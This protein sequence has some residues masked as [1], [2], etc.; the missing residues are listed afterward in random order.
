MPPAPRGPATWYVP[1]RVPGERG[2]ASEC[3]PPRAGSQP[4]PRLILEDEGDL[5]VHPVLRD[6]P[7]FDPQLLLLD[8]G[9]LHVLEGLVRSLD[10]DPGG[11]LEAFRGRGGD[12]GDACDGHG[13]CSSR[14]REGF[15][16]A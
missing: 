5:H 15:A 8:P 7:A 4:A 14:V 12:L 11:I 10:A 9:A 16:G 13:G 6:L 3:R 2:I 1:R